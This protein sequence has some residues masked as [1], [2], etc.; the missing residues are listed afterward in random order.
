MKQYAMNAP[1]HGGTYSLY[2]LPMVLQ[3]Q[4]T[5]PRSSTESA[6]EAAQQDTEVTSV[7][8]HYAAIGPV[9]VVAKAVAVIALSSLQ[10]LTIPRPFC[11]VQ[12]L[13]G[14]RQRLRGH[15]ESVTRVSRER[16]S[17]PWLRMMYVSK[18]S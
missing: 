1:K 7:M 16:G 14:G 5:C 13:A 10:V 12:R 2:Q 11:V 8:R 9:A 4:T 17:W 15:A 3:N 18:L 6:Q